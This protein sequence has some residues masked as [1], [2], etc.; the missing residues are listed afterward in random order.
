MFALKPSVQDIGINPRNIYELG[1]GAIVTQSPKNASIE[2]DS[3]I[4]F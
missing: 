3:L 4:R 2:P 1:A